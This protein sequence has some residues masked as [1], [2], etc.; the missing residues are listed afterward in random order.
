MY[1]AE[2]RQ[3]DDT[4][5][6]FFAWL[7]QQDLADDTLFVITSDHGEEFQE[8]GNL[9][10]GRTHVATEDSRLRSGRVSKQ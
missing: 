6:R 7:D 2:I 1:D 9:L 4:L 3:L 8:H 10:H 5:L